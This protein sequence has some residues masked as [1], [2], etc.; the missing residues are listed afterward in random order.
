MPFI[1]DA[2][3]KKVTFYDLD[4]DRS[5]EN[6]DCSFKSCH[7]LAQSLS[8]LCA[9]KNKEHGNNDLFVKKRW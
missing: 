7:R 2:C 9:Y 1:T 8:I 6:R 3:L 4:Q 5:L